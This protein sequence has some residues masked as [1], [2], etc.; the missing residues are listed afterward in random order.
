MAA[1]LI[2]DTAV[3]DADAYEAYRVP[4][5]SPAYGVWVGR[6]SPRHPGHAYLA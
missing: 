6:G 5:R 2:V 3:H 4:G 1:W